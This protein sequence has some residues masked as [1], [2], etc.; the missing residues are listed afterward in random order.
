MINYYKTGSGKR[1][2]KID[3]ESINA[4]FLF[5]DGDKKVKNIITK[6]DIYNKMVEESQNT[7][8]WTPSDE[9][10]FNEAFAQI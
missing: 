9:T 8:I 3:D 5:I 6:T 7:D 10:T 4:I 2:L 1:Y